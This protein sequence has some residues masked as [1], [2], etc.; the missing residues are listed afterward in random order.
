MIAD[1]RAGPFAAI[2]PRWTLV[3]I[4]EAI[5]ANAPKHFPFFCVGPFTVIAL[6][7]RALS[8]LLALSHSLPSRGAFQILLAR[9]HLLLSRQATY[10]DCC[11]L[12]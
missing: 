4:A 7:I 11:I 1:T 8:I 5:A 12:R 10:F 6:G 2:T 9:S 3:L